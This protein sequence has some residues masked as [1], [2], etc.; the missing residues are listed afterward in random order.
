MSRKKRGLKILSVKVQ[1]LVFKKKSTTYKDVANE[2]IKQLRE[3]KSEIGDL[4]DCDSGDGSEED[5]ASEEM[6][7]KQDKDACEMQQ[8][9]EKNVRRRVYDA[10]NVLY[11]A[12]V[13]QKH[14]KH[15]SCDSNVLLLTR[16]LQEGKHPGRALCSKS[17]KT[18]SD[19]RLL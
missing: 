17:C 3:S 13:L 8:K 9:W 10:L 5:D 16:K 18:Q 4:D 19:L 11:A 1:E 6:P 15:V 14:G 2:L 7:R 12:G